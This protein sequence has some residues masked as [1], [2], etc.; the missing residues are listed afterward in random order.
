MRTYLIDC[1]QGTG[2]C[3]WSYENPP[4]RAEIVE[5]FDCFRIT[6]GMDFPKKALTLKFIA[7]FWEVSIQP[8]R[9]NYV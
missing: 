9:G 2:F 7:D 3:S 1:L 8:N 4:T 6:E 5:H